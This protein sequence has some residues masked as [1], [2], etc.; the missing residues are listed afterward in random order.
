MKHINH[1]YAKPD[2]P[3]FSTGYVVGGRRLGGERKGS[4]V[5]KEPADEASK[6][7]SEAMAET[8]EDDSAS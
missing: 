3:I 4:T 8:R 7:S 5:P 2:D 1:G 6:E